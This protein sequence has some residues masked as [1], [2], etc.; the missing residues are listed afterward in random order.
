MKNTI[1]KR[2]LTVSLTATMLLSATAFS[3]SATENEKSYI[4]TEFENENSDIQMETPDSDYEYLYVSK[5]SSEY[6]D[7]DGYTEDYIKDIYYISA[8]AY[9]NLVTQLMSEVT[10]SIKCDTPNLYIIDVNDSKNPVDVKAEYVDGKYVFK[11]NH[12]GNFALST[13]PLESKEYTLK[14]QTI[15]DPDTGIV[16][17]GMLPENVNYDIKVAWWDHEYIDDY[18]E[19]NKFS[20][21][22]F[23]A[24]PISNL[25]TFNYNS[26]GIINDYGW[27]DPK[28]ASTYVPQIDI[29]FYDEFKV[30]DVKSDLTVTLPI[31][32]YK[33]TEIANNSNVMV[34]K[35]YPE[36]NTIKGVQVLSKENSPEGSVVFKADSTGTFF[37][38]N[39]STMNTF[40][41]TF[42]TS[43]KDVEVYNNTN[44][45]ENENNAPTDATQATEN[46]T[47]TDTDKDTD[48]DNNK[49]NSSKEDEKSSPN[50][51]NTSQ[52]NILFIGIG[53][54][55]ILLAIVA[56]VVIKTKRRKS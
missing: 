12:L 54:V 37:L 2:L 19:Y 55:V 11:T 1:L 45:N 26:D 38:G 51:G 42:G 33:Y 5:T 41:S 46:T 30:I 39:E 13:K 9:Y 48:Q 43:L 22:R 27:L 47:N 15:T 18:E 16:I 34:F 7:F 31:D 52:N 8:H 50:T 24:P 14:E 53:V 32:Y 23:S 6:P 56:V 35:S 25:Y 44:T 17:K 10:L 28:S 3:V 4:V 20:D 36:E 21:G 29:V 49:D 40:L